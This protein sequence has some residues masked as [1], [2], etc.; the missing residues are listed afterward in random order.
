VK[1]RNKETKGGTEVK[2]TKRAKQRK[3]ETQKERNKER[4]KQRK[5]ETKKE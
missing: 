1:Q 3:S 5:S 2:H 4:A